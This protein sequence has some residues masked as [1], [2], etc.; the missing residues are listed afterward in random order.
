MFQK[1][2]LEQACQLLSQ[3]W[4][5]MRLGY[6]DDDAIQTAVYCQVDINRIVWKLNTVMNNKDDEEELP[7]KIHG[8]IWIDKNTFELYTEDLIRKRLAEAMVP[9]L[10]K[11]IQID[12]IDIGEKGIFSVDGILTVMGKYVV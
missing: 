2:R 6:I 12:P 7:I 1:E 5:E 8:R 4:E 10:S 11:C 3:V 9:E